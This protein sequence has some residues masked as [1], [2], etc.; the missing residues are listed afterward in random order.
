MWCS[1][2]LS[3]RGSLGKILRHYHGIP[4]RRQSWVPMLRWSHG[5]AAGRASPRTRI[6]TWTKLPI[7]GIGN[8][9]TRSLF[10]SF[11]SPYYILK[12][13]LCWILFCCP[14]RYGNRNIISG[15]SSWSGSTRSDPYQ[16]DLHRSLKPPN[17][18]ASPI[19][20]SLKILNHK[21]ANK[22]KLIEFRWEKRVGTHG[23]EHHQLSPGDHG[24]TGQ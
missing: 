18:Y 14:S 10:E 21:R 15:W 24:V 6:P 2:N 17:L 22:I 23:G 4:W 13:I 8:I 5:T 20:M 3:S 9:W 11:P 19:E 7:L 16:E 1:T 12:H